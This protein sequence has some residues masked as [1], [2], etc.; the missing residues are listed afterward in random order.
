M[1]PDSTTIEIGKAPS[2]C[3]KKRLRIQPKRLCPELVRYIATRF[4]E[5]KKAKN[6]WTCSLAYCCRQ[7][8]TYSIAWVSGEA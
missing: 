1:P 3:W 4:A 8:E 2:A 7:L 5:A 6:V